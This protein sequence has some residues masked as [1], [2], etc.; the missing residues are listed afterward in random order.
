MREELKKLFSVGS[1]ITISI[2]ILEL[3]GEI[4]VVH[5]IAQDVDFKPSI[6]EL[7]NLKATE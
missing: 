5:A 7:L 6:K 1:I 4:L 3:G 2:V